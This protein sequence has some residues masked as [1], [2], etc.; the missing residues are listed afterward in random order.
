MISN[1]SELQYHDITL[2]GTR[3]IRTAIDMGKSGFGPYLLQ[4]LDTQG[5]LDTRLDPHDFCINGV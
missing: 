1:V 3:L 4:L 2:D 5:N